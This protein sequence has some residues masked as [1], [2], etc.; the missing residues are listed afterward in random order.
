MK[1]PRDPDDRRDLE[2]QP[3]PSVSTG[4]SSAH[5]LPFATPLPAPPVP[6]AKLR[7]PP[8]PSPGLMLPSFAQSRQAEPVPTMPVPLEASDTGVEL[9]SRLMFRVVQAL[10]LGLRVLR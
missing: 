9:R 5:M 3:S 4:A 1:R 8:L 7:A 10:L 6:K 2:P